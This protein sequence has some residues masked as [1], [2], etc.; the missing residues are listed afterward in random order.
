M[1]PHIVDHTVW[2]KITKSHN[3]TRRTEWDCIEISNEIVIWL[4]VRSILLFWTENHIANAVIAPRLWHWLHFPQ[5]HLT[6]K[7]PSVCPNLA[8]LYPGGWQ[9]LVHYWSDIRKDQKC[10]QTRLMVTKCGQIWFILTKSMSLLIFWLKCG[11]ICPHQFLCHFGSN[12]LQ[13]GSLVQTLLMSAF[14]CKTS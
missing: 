11:F 5:K 6:T 3:N 2:K 4:T 1:Y 8:I 9:Q 13:L 7:L 10:P 12:C 14:K